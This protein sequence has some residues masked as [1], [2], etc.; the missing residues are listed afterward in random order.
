[1]QQ[2]TELE[3]GKYNKNLTDRIAE[4][5][6]QGKDTA[7]FLRGDRFKSSAETV[8]FMDAV[9]VKEIKLVVRH[10]VKVGTPF[11]L[12]FFAG[13]S[14]GIVKPLGFD[15]ASGSI[16]TSTILEEDL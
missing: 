11:T 10:T 6:V 2:I 3:V 13:D 14:L 1:M 8:D 7:A 16:N 9:K 12:G 5:L 15:S 4:L